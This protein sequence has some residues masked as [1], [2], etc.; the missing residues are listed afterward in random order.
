MVAKKSVIDTYQT[1]S[2]WLTTTFPYIKTYST[3]TLWIRKSSTYNL[4]CTCVNNTSLLLLSLEE[5]GQPLRHISIR[6]RSKAIPSEEKQAFTLVLAIFSVISYLCCSV[7]AGSGGKGN[8]CLPGSSANV[9]TNVLLLTSTRLY[10]SWHFVCLLLPVLA[11]SGY[12]WLLL[13]TFWT[14]VPYSGAKWYYIKVSST[15][16]LSQEYISAAW[17]LGIFY[18]AS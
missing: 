7:L 17:Y 6:N 11:I 5:E 3:L 12:F 9:V 4:T 2:M 14:H 16:K 1:Y 18:T 10:V 15:P 13:A 8:V